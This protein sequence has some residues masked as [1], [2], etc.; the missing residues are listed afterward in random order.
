LIAAG[1]GSDAVTELLYVAVCSKPGM[2]YFQSVSANKN[3]MLSC[4]VQVR[5]RQRSVIVHS[6]LS[7][8][9]QNV[10]FIATL[11]LS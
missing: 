11:M 4:V 3:K 6:Q 5:E 1:R 8:V 10:C 9:L 2:F 7:I